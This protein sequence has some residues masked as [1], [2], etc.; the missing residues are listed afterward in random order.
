M[1]D[2]A[3]V[4]A[5]PLAIIIHLLGTVSIRAGGK[6]KRVIIMDP[7]TGEINYGSKYRKQFVLHLGNCRAGKVE[8]QPKTIDPSMAFEIVCKVIVPLARRGFR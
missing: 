1:V 3:P 6:S 7:N 2:P 4:L 8:N 5:S